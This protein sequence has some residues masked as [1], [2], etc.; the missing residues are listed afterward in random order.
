M[1]FKATAEHDSRDL[2]A[3][4]ASNMSMSDK[5]EYIWR[6]WHVA[7]LTFIRTHSGARHLQIEITMRTLKETKGLRGTE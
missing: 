7:E 4:G 6:A 3:T 1:R 2:G 5:H